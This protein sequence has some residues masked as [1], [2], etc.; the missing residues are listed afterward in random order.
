[1]M[2]LEPTLK[3][4]DDLKWKVLSPS[5]RGEGWGPTSFPDLETAFL[6]HKYQQNWVLT[7][8]IDIEITEKPDKSIT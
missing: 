8:V 2:Q 6:A 7:K 5:R 3:G 1:M 4:I